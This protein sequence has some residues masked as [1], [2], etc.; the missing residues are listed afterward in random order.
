MANG[1]LYLLYKAVYN[2][3][4]HPLRHYPGP[5]WA[6]ASRIPF[7]RASLGGRLA[8]WVTEIHQNYGEVVR[9]APDDL[10]FI[11]PQAW[12][13]IYVHRP[14]HGTFQKDP[15]FYITPVNGAHSLITAPDK[16]HSRM[17]R[18][19]SH[20]FSEKAL[21]EMEPVIRSYVDLL[22]E[23][24]HEVTQKSA[25]AP[26]D[27][28]KWYNWTTF[29]VIGDLTV[30][31]SFHCLE[32]A[33]YHPWVSFLFEAIKSSV[34]IMASRRYP[35]MKRFIRWAV[36]ERVLRRR[37][38]HLR[39]TAEH[40]DKRLTMDMARPDFVSYILRGQDEK[41]MSTKEMHS[42]CSTIL[43]A[44]SETTATLLSGL[45]FYLLTNPDKYAKL[46]NEI[47][48]RFQS[49]DE[50]NTA[51]ISK[52]SYVQASV[53][54]GL[55]MYPPVPTGLPRVVPKGGD[56][57]SGRWVPGNT[58]VSVTQLAAYRSEL[59]F[60]DPYS[61]VP[62]RWLEKKDPAFELDRRD[63]LQPF[64]VGGRNCIG[65]HL[66]YAEMRLILVKLL[67]NFDLAFSDPISQAHWADQQVFTL[68]QKLPLMVKLTP[69]ART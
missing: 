58:S 20:A 9:T 3:Y 11:D 12:K 15:M 33:D 21:K 18:L 29:D 1:L 46:V 54:E 68:W 37:E 63:V 22:I 55:R 35:F 62:E 42:N 27:M 13:D 38:D 57:V 41:G 25:G 30:G 43:V 61:F 16:D 59:N 31:E 60:R 28:V 66:A 24:L 2:V 44:G 32:G 56:Y 49:E 67:W 17:R 5:R 64:S 50:M 39:Y 10:S 23:R 51:E 19:V 48:G 40:V 47:R 65:K 7:L 45:T 6:A 14:Q 53:E 8:Q 26:V 36:P 69:V 52:M 34:F 4:F